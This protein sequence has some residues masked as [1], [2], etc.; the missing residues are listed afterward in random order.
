MS[1][2]NGP[3]RRERRGYANGQHSTR[4][5]LAHGRYKPKAVPAEMNEI[6]RGMFN[7]ATTSGVP[8]QDREKGS[9]FS[10]TRLNRDELVRSIYRFLRT[11][12]DDEDAK[13]RINLRQYWEDDLDNISVTAGLLA[14]ASYSLV[15]SDLSNASI[16]VFSPR[17]VQIF[18]AWTVALFVGVIV[19]CQQQKFSLRNEF[20]E[21]SDAYKGFRCLAAICSRAIIALMSQAALMLLFLTISAFVWHVGLLFAIL[22]GIWIAWTLSAWTWWIFITIPLIRHESRPKRVEETTSN[23]NQ[24]AD[25]EAQVSH[26]HPH[27]TLGEA[28]FRVIYRAFHKTP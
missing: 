4:A 20:R 27:T 23:S 3:E 25:V 19:L 12:D 22:D 18:A 16:S 13:D 15:T 24:P 7:S 10:R 14:L 21:E 6:A 1:S 5:S 28:V 9:C 17:Q 8:S 11:V 2:Q 26:P